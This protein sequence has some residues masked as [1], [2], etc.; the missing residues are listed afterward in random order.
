MGALPRC[1]YGDYGAPSFAEAR[2]ASSALPMDAARG[3]VRSGLGLDVHCCIGFGFRVKRA[4]GTITSTIIVLF[5]III[6]V[7]IIVVIT[8]R[9]VRGPSGTLHTAGC[10]LTCVNSILPY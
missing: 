9:W 3:R 6:V 8:L 10:D 7:I 5:I 1:R 4:A 2:A